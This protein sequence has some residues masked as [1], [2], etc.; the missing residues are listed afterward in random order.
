VHALGIDQVAGLGRIEQ[1]RVDRRLRKEI[2]DVPEDA[3]RAAAL[4]QVVVNEG[5]VQP[6]C[7]GRTSATM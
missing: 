1:R 6:F 2:R 3:F 5:G 7:R 4:V